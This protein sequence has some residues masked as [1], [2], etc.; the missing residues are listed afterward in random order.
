MFKTFFA[1]V[2]VRFTKLVSPVSV[3]DSGRVALGSAFRLATTDTGRV[4]LGS[5]FRLP[6]NDVGRIKLGSAFRLAA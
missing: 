2:A 4:E 5:A 3:F 6:T 1:F